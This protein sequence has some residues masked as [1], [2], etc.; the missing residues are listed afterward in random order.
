[1]KPFGEIMKRVCLKLRF[2][3]YVSLSVFCVTVQD[4]EE[5][6]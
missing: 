2:Q 4:E 6:Y 5:E 3:K 1:M